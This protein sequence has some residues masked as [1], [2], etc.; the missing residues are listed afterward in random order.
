MT[1][2]V[3]TLVDVVESEAYKKHQ[4]TPQAIEN[5]LFD[6]GMDI[7]KGFEQMLCKCRST[8]RGAVATTT[9]YQGVWRTD[10][11]WKDLEYK[12]KCKYG[13]RGVY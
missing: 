10:K 11:A 12:T 7:T 13:F 4:G 5:T 9:R 8:I 3:L 2:H 1:D 6:L